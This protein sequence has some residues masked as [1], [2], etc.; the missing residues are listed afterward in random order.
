[1]SQGKLFKGTIYE[2]WTDEEM[3]ALSPDFQYKLE[4]KTFSWPRLYYVDMNE[5]EGPRLRII[6]PDGRC[7]WTPLNDMSWDAM[8]RENDFKDFFECKPCWAQ[9]TKP[10]D[11]WSALKKMKRYDINFKIKCEFIGEIK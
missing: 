5:F 7:Y 3:N 11:G 6:C 1:M 9:G 10:T 4:P 2:N 8:D